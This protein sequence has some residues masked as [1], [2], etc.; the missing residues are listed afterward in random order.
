MKKHFASMLAL[1]LLGF[2]AA[3]QAAPNLVVNGDFELNGGLGQLGTTSSATGWSSSPG[4]V[5][6]GFSNVTPFNFI[7]D[8]S[9]DSVGF[10]SEN[11]PPN[12]KVWGPN[13]GSNNGF[14]GSAN[15]GF[16]LGGDGGYATA[17]VVQ[18]ITGLIV[19]T[20]YDLHFEW[21]G[22][23]FTDVT[24]PYYAGW[25]VT[26][27]G[28]TQSVV[29]GPLGSIA[30]QGFL[31][32]ANAHM[33]FTATSA[34]DVLSFLATGPVGLPPFSLLDGVSITAVP[35]PSSVLMML[36]GLGGLGMVARRRRQQA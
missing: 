12:I 32:W 31:P 25:D 35:E 8:A 11:S 30:S 4:T 9:A 7:V 27:A 18:S 16:F 6:N 33:T 26:I 5:F 34:T 1:P 2:M 3:A 24:G 19:G 17:A 36:A 13:S 21:A 29:S 23:Q 20:Q 14:T 15:G 22:A 28:Q 10:S